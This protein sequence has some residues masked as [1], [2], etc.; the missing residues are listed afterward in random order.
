VTACRRQHGQPPALTGR[1]QQGREQEARR[2]P[3]ARDTLGRQVACV[4]KRACK[5][6]RREEQH[7][8]AQSRQA[9]EREHE[10]GRRRRIAKPPSAQRGAHR[11]Y[12]AARV[13]SAK[14]A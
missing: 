7:E 2:R 8:E 10:D 4:S 6:V 11:S 5:Q 1:P 9:I 3:Y 13:G 12:T 14:V